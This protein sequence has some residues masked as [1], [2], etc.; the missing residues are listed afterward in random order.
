MFDREPGL[1]SEA[2][3]PGRPLNND[4]ITD[5]IQAFQY[6]ER[7][8]SELLQRPE[9]H[10]LDSETELA[11]D[12]RNEALEAATKHYYRLIPFI[13]SRHF[14]I[15]QTD[16]DYEDCMQAGFF[17]IY[18]ALE[19]SDLSKLDEEEPL[20]SLTSYVADWIKQKIATQLD[21][22]T[23][24]VRLPIYVRTQVR[25]LRERDELLESGVDD[26]ARLAFLDAS[27]IDYEPKLRKAHLIANRVLPLESGRSWGS[28]REYTTMDGSLS[29]KP[30]ISETL[31]D[32]EDHY[33]V[34]ENELQIDR[35]F[36]IILEALNEREKKVL[37]LRFG[38]DDGEEKT[39]QK[40]GEYFYLSRERIRSIE[41]L[42]L[43]KIRAYIYNKNLN[44]ED[45]LW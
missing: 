37:E 18:R 20:R 4:N 16:Q 21:N 13:L 3:I 27:I 31:I 28:S 40:V 32:P 1:A 38:L 30:E 26:P 33:E 35:F 11:L 41:S 6:G 8:W 44:P 34:V 36:G 15:R 10:K 39:L 14:H 24:T 42:A 2:Q 45:Y 43:S 23:T 29:L 25:K 7:V 19:I 9:D 5:V 22:E 12:A 17:G